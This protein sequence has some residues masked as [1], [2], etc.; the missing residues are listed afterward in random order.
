VTDTTNVNV[1]PP[2]I[3][4]ADANSTTRDFQ[5]IHI[6]LSEIAAD[7][8]IIPV[9]YIADSADVERSKALAY[10][11]EV[12]RRNAFIGNLDELA[13]LDL[14]VGISRPGKNLNYTIII[15]QF[16]LTPAGAFADAYCVF[17]VP[18]SGDKIAFKGSNIEFSYEG[19][20]KGTGR[21][22]LIG[23]YPIKMNDKTLLTILGKGN[24]FVEFNCDGFKQMGIEA[25]IEFSRD[26]IVPETDLGDIKP[27]PERVRSKFQFVAQDW[28]D[29]LV[30]VSLPPF[31]VNGLKGFGFS[32]R[33]AY[34]DWSDLANPTGMVFPTGYTSSYIAAGQDKLWRGFYMRELDVR[35]P[36]SFSTKENQ[37]RMAFGVQDMI[38]DDQGFTGIIHG[39]NLISAGDMNG[40]SYT[41]DRLGIQLITNQIKGF[42]LLGRLTVPVIKSENGQPSSFNY[43]A[44]R[45]ADG[46]Y[47]FSVKFNSQ[48][49]LPMFV[50]DV[51]LFEGTTFI[52]VEKNNRFFPS[53]RLNGEL[54]IRALSKGPK[55]S[56]NA[57]RFENMIISSEKPH[58]TPGAFS[59][60]S[61]NGSSSVSNFP[62]SI[63]KI[64]VKSEDNRVG[65]DFNLEVHIGGKAEDE[66][67]GGSA[68]L[69]LWGKQEEPQQG[70]TEKQTQPSSGRDWS[71][72]KVEITGISVEVVKPGVI[73]VKGLVDFFDG[74]ATYG[75]GFKGS[76]SGKIQMIT[77]QANALFGRTNSYRYWYA[78]ALVAL[79]NGIVIIPGVLS[80]Y[81]FGGGYY[82][83]M[84]QSS[85]PVTGNIGKTPSGITYVPNE[86]TL[87]IRAVVLIGATRKEAWN[88]DVALEVALNKHGGINSVTLSGNAY[89]MSPNVAFAAADKVKS[90]T[91]DMV[92]NK[93]SQKLADV[94]KGSKGTVYGSVKLFFDHAN[95]V[96]HGNLEIYVNVAGGILR[97]VSDGN[98]AG[99]AT[100]HFAKD[101]WYVLI[102]TPTQP[103]G[104]EVARIFKTSS[105]FMMGKNL[106]GSPPPP[107]QVTEILGDVSLDYMR[108]MNALQSGTGYAFGISSIIDTGELTFLVFYARLAAG[109]GVDFMMKDYGPDCYCEGQTGSIGV[110]GWYAN[111][112][113]YA[114]IIGKIG[115]KVK[116]KF[117]K[118]NFD[119]INVGAAAILQAKGPNPIWFHGIVGGHYNILGGL[120]KGDCKF[121]MTIGRECKIIQPSKQQEN[122][123]SDVTIIAGVSP[124]AD[125]R[126]VDVFTA[127]QVAFNMPINQSFDISAEN[128]GARMFRGTLSKF[129]VVDGPA[130]IAGTLRWNDTKDVVIFD[131]YD[132][133]PP[134]KQLKITAQVT[135]EENKEGLWVPMM[136][137]G[138]PMEETREST[139]TTGDAPAF[140][141]ASNVDIAYPAV[142][143]FNFY[144]KEYGEGFIELKKGQGY[145]F[146]PG[147]D[148][149]QKIRIT[150]AMGQAYVETDLRYNEGE[151]RIYYSIP[152]GLANSKAYQ[153]NIMNFPKQTTMIDAN[154]KNIEQ[155]VN[156]GAD[157]TVTTKQIEGTVELKE[158]TTIYSALFRTSKFN[159]FKEKVSAISLGTT[160]RETVGFNVYQ[161][162]GYMNANAELFD[163][164][165]VNERFA[166]RE[167]QF[168]AVL[169][170]NTWYQNSVYPL[171]YEGFPLTSGMT[172]RYRNTNEFGFPPVKALY[173]DQAFYYPVL[174]EDNL[175]AT[176]SPVSTF[177][178]VRYDV[179]NP[180]KLDYLDIQN[181]VANLVVTNPSLLT[182]R[183]S[184]L[185]VTSFP[186]LQYGKYRL[187]IKYVVPRINKVTS[188]HEWQ[189]FNTITDVND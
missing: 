25:E 117:V 179:M 118:G 37:G 174:T 154:V 102:G 189:L 188:T 106:P 7:P 144:P 66:G 95:D 96:F 130:E 82:S 47:L 54:T 148:W 32:V 125:T 147:P 23:N 72:D 70:S 128:E 10:Q 165:E 105:Y 126:N 26:L 112:Q 36:S 71:F 41:L 59:F 158:V 12:L 44:Q 9:Q 11:D 42:E 55:A 21:L 17:E 46:N 181:Q 78:D 89:F 149:I 62:V 15:S 24:S 124:E 31:Q 135:F 1:F 142:G 34:L 157:M 168:E 138:K 69:T 166:D 93:L 113:A 4:V 99:W 51:K 161:L 77:V 76:L 91:T 121:E 122:P 73:E 136:F 61:D 5:Q 170:D 186:V 109:I 187:R 110:N 175:A 27:N 81:G 57:I 83:N 88:G 100:L 97:G 94:V 39:D 68:N 67:F 80:A 132:V 114:F 119:I 143:Q 3:E 176:F 127:P 19:G 87:G 155:N 115:I 178:S 159:T 101:D 63:K 75:D 86:N 48:V 140:I 58:F 180:M 151:R 74:D 64:G 182:A 8:I 133:L 185:L 90:M 129:K 104:L 53:G 38:L 16:K 153:F 123:L 79:D 18:Q 163:Y 28:N 172:I 141:P 116:L 108:D 84:K 131:S 164:S 60:G 65:L 50:A 45:G 177:N 30:G 160:F 13:L 173:V 137:E 33:S 40:W 20:F 171:V 162:F 183:M 111:G 98:K 107:S 184:S 134:K 156:A 139:F 92:G 167:V 152:N 14:P 56:F 146:N 120:V 103:I 145:L 22:E 43:Q 6:P 169:D 85:E 2:A 29:V 49:K 150:E 52:V 35:L